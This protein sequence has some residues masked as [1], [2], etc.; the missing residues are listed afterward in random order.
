MVPNGAASGAANLDSS[1][2]LKKRS[3]NRTYRCHPDPH[4]CGDQEA[5]QVNGRLCVGS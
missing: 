1:A 3:S 4:R 2:V 5:C